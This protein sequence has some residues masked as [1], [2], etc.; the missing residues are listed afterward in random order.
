MNKNTT[1]KLSIF[2]L[3]S[4][5][6]CI[7]GNSILYMDILSYIIEGISFLS[8]LFFAIWICQ[9]I[10]GKTRFSNNW[11]VLIMSFALAIYSF[12]SS[13]ITTSEFLWEYYIYF[14]YLFVL[15]CLVSSIVLVGRM[16][17][18]PKKPNY[19]EQSYI[20]A[21]QPATA[22]IPETNIWTCS[23]G[24]NNTGNFCSECGNPLVVAEITETAETSNI[25]E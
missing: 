15:I 21:P 7:I 24:H 9:L 4:T 1:L 11:V 25:S 17:F 5:I 12:V 23:C 20:V 19:S 16:M 13:T 2:A 8:Y 22:H 6:I 14:F 18:S 3:I 10:Y